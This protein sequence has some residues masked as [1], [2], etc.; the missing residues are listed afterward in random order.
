MLMP[1]ADHAMVDAFKAHPGLEPRQIIP[2]FIR[3]QQS[4]HVVDE[5]CMCVCSRCVCVCVR[6]VCVCVCECVCVC[7][8]ASISERSS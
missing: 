7:D 6:G 8:R 2:A 5:V 4:K 3:Y 1:H